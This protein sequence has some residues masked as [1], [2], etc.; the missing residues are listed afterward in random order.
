MF[1]TGRA[2][3]QEDTREEGG[4]RWTVAGLEVVLAS[5][6]GSCQ[7]SEGEMAE[8]HCTRLQSGQTGWGKVQ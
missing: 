2:A 8:T 3:A 7:L 6:A 4:A 5:G 1:D